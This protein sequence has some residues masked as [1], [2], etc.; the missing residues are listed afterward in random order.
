MDIK[1]AEVLQATRGRALTDFPKKYLRIHKV[2]TDT[3]RLEKGDIFFALKGPNFDGHA[4]IKEA[5]E[6]GAQTLVVSRRGAVSASVKKSA[7][8]IVVKDT[9]KAYGD[10]AKFYR[11]KFKIPV[12]A[13]TGSCGKTTVKEMIAHVLSKRFKTLK[14]RGTENNL[15]GVPKTLFQL[16]PSHE[17]AVI[18]M[19]TNQPGEIL[20]LSQ[21]AAPQIAVV[22]QIGSSHLEG[23]KSPEGIKSEKLSLI[24]ALERGGLLIL[25]GEDPL[26]ADFKSGAHRVLKVGFDP[27]AHDLAAEK[28][29]CCDLGSAFYVQ[30]HLFRTPLL[31]R[32]NILNCLFAILVSRAMGMKFPV[33]REA[34]SSFKPAPGRL[35]LREM[36]GVLFLDD[37]YNANPTSFKA[38]LET[39]K[40]FKIRE[41][42]GV[43]CGDMLELGTG[44]LNYHRQLGAMIAELLPDFVIAAGLLSKALVDEAV[45]K[46]YSPKRIHHVKDSV[47]AGKVCRQMAA[48]GDTILVKGSRAMAMEKVFECFITSSTR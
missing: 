8:V 17:A 11:R 15:V 29:R 24:H 38:A 21:M 43:V 42:K 46:G 12:I 35:N 3:R 44:A 13:V 37:T 26:L 10:L 14:N 25:N 40:E 27:K 34:I 6:K 4:F 23:L 41:K 31:G 9:L 33:I 16:D 30:K 47:E 32:H 20:R 39:L 48:P 36:E 1:V 5:L 22:T 19:G 2:S 45:K 18:E 28:I 7:G